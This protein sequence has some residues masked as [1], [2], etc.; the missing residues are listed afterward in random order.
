MDQQ[1]DILTLAYKQPYMYNE[2]EVLQEVVRNVPGSVQYAIK[3]YKKH[4]QWNM[5]DTG[6]LVYNYAKNNTAENYLRRHTR[7]FR[8]SKSD[9]QLPRH[10][11]NANAWPIPWRSHVYG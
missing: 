1:I 9:D 10:I 11:Y 3:R 8:R 7:P 2:M 4:T 6:V 5:E